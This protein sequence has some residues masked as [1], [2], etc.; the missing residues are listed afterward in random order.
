METITPTK[1]LSLIIKSTIAPEY[2]DI[3]SDDAL[4]FVEK[5][6]RKFRLRRQTLLENR[7][8]SQ[9]MGETLWETVNFRSQ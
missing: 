5:L 3:L 7:I 8:K 6:E 1:Q 9:E 4:L 2:E